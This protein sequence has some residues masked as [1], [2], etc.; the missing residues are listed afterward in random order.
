MP[1]TVL[2][3]DDNPAS[4]AHFGESTVRAYQLA[5]TPP[6]MPVV[7][8]AD[9]VLQESAMPANFDGR[10]PKLPKLSAPAGDPV[11]VAELAQ[12]LVAAENP[13]I[14]TSRTS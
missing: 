8:A 14:V 4:L 7:L 11:A 10:I 12:L 2:V 6:T 1:K 13:V 9:G 5:M 3:V